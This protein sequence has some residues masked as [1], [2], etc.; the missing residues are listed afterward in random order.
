MDST[1]TIPSLPDG[2]GKPAWDVARLFP[3]QG[4]WSEHE[5]LNLNGNHLVEFSDGCVEVLPMPTM[6]HQMMVL[7]LYGKLSEFVAPHGL[8]RLLVAPFRVR[9][10][11]GKYREP[12][13][14]FMLTSH[15]SRM[16]E[17]YW[18][19]ADLVLEVVSN[20]D[21]RRDL[22]TK[23]IEYAQA[24]IP[25]YWIVDPQQSVITVFRLLGDSYVIHGQFG[26]EARATSVLLP[27][28]EID[29]AAVFAITARS[30]QEA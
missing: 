13:L 29:V 28:F 21:R 15:A 8:G 9:L 10:W 12:D 14:C 26:V 25:E 24:R 23:R 20:D 6:M 11:E 17:L 27:G 16:H 4:H 18:E 19:G 7:W 22:E 1:V 2:I 30:D 3:N 5:Y